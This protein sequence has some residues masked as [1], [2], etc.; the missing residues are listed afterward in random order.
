MYFASHQITV[1]VKNKVEEESESESEVVE[2]E[3]EEESESKVEED[4]EL[5]KKVRIKQEK[6]AMMMKRKT[7]L[8]L[9]KTTKTFKLH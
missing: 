9:R 8:K 1:W 4:E 2:N 5:V 7:C 6:I 3:F